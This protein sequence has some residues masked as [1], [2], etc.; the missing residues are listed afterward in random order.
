MK[1]AAEGSSLDVGL[2]AQYG[3]ALR[4]HANAA[5]VHGRVVE[6]HVG[7]ACLSFLQQGHSQP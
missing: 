4:V 2:I 7:P 3:V 5:E 1:I 6:H